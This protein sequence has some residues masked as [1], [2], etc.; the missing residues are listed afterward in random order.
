MLDPSRRGAGLRQPRD[1]RRSRPDLPCGRAAARCPGDASVV[2][3]R[4]ARGRSSRSRARS[5]T[6]WA[7]AI[8]DDAL[9]AVG[10]QGFLRDLAAGRPV[11]RRPPAPSAVVRPGGPGRCQPARPRARDEHRDAGGIPSPR[12][13]PARDAGTPRRPAGHRRSATA[14]PRSSATCR[15]RP[16]AKSTRREPATRSWRPCSRRCSD[17]RWSVG[18]AHDAARTSGSRRPPGRSRWS[19][20]VSPASRIGR[21]CSS[22]G[23]ANAS[24]GRSSRARCHRSGRAGSTPTDGRRRRLAIGGSGEPAAQARD[25]A[26]RSASSAGSGRPEAAAALDGARP[27]ERGDERTGPVAQAVLAQLRRARSRRRPRSVRGRPSAPT[28][29]RPHRDDDRARRSRW[30]RSI[31]IRSAVHGVV[32]LRGAWRTELDR[33]GGRPTEVRRPARRPPR[34][35]AAR[36]RVRVR[37][38]SDRAAA[39]TGPADRGASRQSSASPSRRSRANARASPARSPGGASART[40][41]SPRRVSR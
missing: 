34:F 36:D 32:E 5:V 15:P 2:A 30:A 8:P 26:G 16:T 6:S 31:R 9:V 18:P 22:A 41:A 37:A 29:H 1:A 17:P 3:T 39:A 21:P 38:G 10:W 25:A 7:A 14:R 23:R 20:R 28:R 11:A 35:L 19:A 33:A 27:L 12:R 4:R 24:G 13:G 40:A